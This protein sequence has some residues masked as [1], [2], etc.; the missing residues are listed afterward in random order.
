MCLQGPK[1][2]KRRTLQE[3]NFSGTGLGDAKASADL[4]YRVQDL[5]SY[6]NQSQ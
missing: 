5:S 3:L 4:Q 6:Q 1:F 2:E